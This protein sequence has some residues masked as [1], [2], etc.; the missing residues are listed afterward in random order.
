[1]NVCSLNKNYTNYTFLRKKT[2]WLVHTEERN[3][4]SELGTHARVRDKFTTRILTM[5]S[6]MVIGMKVFYLLV[7]LLTKLAQGSKD[8]FTVLPQET[9][10]VLCFITCVIVELITTCS[11][12]KKHYEVA[13]AF[14]QGQHSFWRLPVSNRYR[15]VVTCV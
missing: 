3:V 13:V 4:C 11:K 12:S 2:F 7:Y 15:V 14:H 8:T 6:K 5:I 9:R 1:M 10:K